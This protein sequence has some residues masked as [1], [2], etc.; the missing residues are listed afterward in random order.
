MP[1]PILIQGKDYWVNCVV[2]KGNTASGDINIV[3]ELYDEEPTF[4]D[5]KASTEPVESV[6]LF[7]DAASLYHQ[8][9]IPLQVLNVVRSS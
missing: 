4:S 5:G 3:I 2:T 1:K 9:E 6:H 7:G 8:F